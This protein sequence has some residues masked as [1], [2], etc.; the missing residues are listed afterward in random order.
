MLDVGCSYGD[1][2]RRLKSKNCNVDGVE[3]YEDAIKEAR[4]ILDNVYELDLNNP[5]TAN[6]LITK[7]YSVIT[8]MDVLEHCNNPVAVLAAFKEK[9][10]DN[11]RMYISLPNIVNIKDRLSI[12]AGN[13]NYREY[14]VL[15]KTHLRF[16]TKK[17]A[18]ELVSSILTDVMIVK[19]TP[20]YNCLH[21]IVDFWPEMFALQFVIEG[22]K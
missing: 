22:R 7:Q 12:F 20:L 10:T 4:S 16:F 14:G 3:I 2:G 6:E 19:C 15:D 13:F 18:I 17:T 1:F 11:G 9:L 8:F 21:P 5:A